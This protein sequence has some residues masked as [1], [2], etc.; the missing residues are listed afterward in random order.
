MLVLAA[1]AVVAAMAVA[2]V[3]TASATV[4]CKTNTAPCG[5]K[6]VAGTEIKAS[7]ASGTSNK[8]SSGTGE[9]VYTCSG[10]SLAGKIEAAGSSTETVRASIPASSLTW[11]GCVWPMTTLKGGEMEI[12]W[13]SG[14]ANGTVTAKGIELRVDT[15]GFGTCTYSS[16][17]NAVHMGVLTGGAAP[18][19]DVWLWLGLVGGGVPCRST[20][21]WNSTYTVTSPTP[22]YVRE[23]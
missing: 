21:I 8:F 9:I 6:Y 18:T 19:L 13:I 17:A 11:S 1:L 14:S 16:G 2:G 4:L 15:T 20:V 7:L 12:H 5:E 23:S 3:G 10:G 22:L